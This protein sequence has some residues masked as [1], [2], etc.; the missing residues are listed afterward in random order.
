MKCQRCGAINDTV[1]THS[2]VNECGGCWQW[3]KLDLPAAEHWYKV[4]TAFLSNVD[5]HDMQTYLPAALKSSDKVDIDYA[6][7]LRGA[8]AV[9]Q[10]SKRVIDDGPQHTWE[11]E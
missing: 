7:L 9:K 4:A 2:G 1:A 5:L 10:Y 11:T 6:Q 8:N 3:R